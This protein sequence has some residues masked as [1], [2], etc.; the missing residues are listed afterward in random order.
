MRSEGTGGR[1]VTATAAQVVTSGEL[2]MQSGKCSSNKGY[3]ALE[4]ELSGLGHFADIEHA[5]NAYP[6]REL[7]CCRWEVEGGACFTV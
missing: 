3:G 4:T 2:R 1:V 7:W 6:D 5:P